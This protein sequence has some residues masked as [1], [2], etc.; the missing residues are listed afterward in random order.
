MNDTA[1]R[2]FQFS[3]ETLFAMVTF[4]T[5]LAALP[6]I[7]PVFVAIGWFLLIW[8]IAVFRPES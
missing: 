8:V 7:G 3:L 1:P 6:R 2:R 4:V 5:V